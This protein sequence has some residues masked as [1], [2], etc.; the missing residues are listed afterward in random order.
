MDA[1]LKDLIAKINRNTAAQWEQNE[2]WRLELGLPER[3]TTELELLLQKW[4]QAK[5]AQQSPAPGELLLGQRREEES[6]PVPEEVEPWLSLEP[7]AA[8]KGEKVLSPEP[9]EVKSAPPPQ[10]QPPTPEEYP[11]LVSAVPCPLLL[12]TLP[13]CLDLPVLDLV[14]FEVFFKTS[15]VMTKAKVYNFRKA[16]YEGLPCSQPRTTTSED[17]AALGSLQASP[18]ALGQ[19]IGVAGAR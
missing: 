9:E 14:S 15:K 6:V 3:E 18:K 7:P 2:K 13:V 1:N 16:N 5:E 8:I 19:S 4:E 11:A 12:D 17:N 10:L